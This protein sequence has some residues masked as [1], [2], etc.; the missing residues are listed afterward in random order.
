MPHTLLFMESASNKHDET[1]RQDIIFCQNRKF[2]LVFLYFCAELSEDMKKNIHIL[3]LFA[4]VLTGLVT[5]CDDEDTYA[6]RRKREREQISAFIRNGVQIKSEELNDYILDV[7][8]N[9]KVISEAEFYAN[10]STT[11]VSKNEYVLFGG[12]GVYMQ[13]VRKGSGTKLEHGQS[14]TIVTRCNSFLIAI[15]CHILP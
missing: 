6:D 3:L 12:S 4:V 2:V 5:A 11:D 13:I 1:A 10:D 8:G 9:I 7:P 15:I 14:A